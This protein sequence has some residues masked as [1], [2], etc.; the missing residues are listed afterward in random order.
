MAPPPRPRRVAPCVERLERRDAPAAAPWLAEGFDTVPAGALPPGWAQWASAGPPAFQVS[1][2]RAWSLPQGLASTPAGS[3]VAARAWYATSEPADVLVGASVFLDTA[4]PAGVLLRG[5][6]LNGT[7]A[8]YYAL[9]IS[10]GLDVQLLRVV[11]GVA[12]T[13]ADLHSTQYF[14]QQW[15]RVALWAS[16]NTLRAQVTRLD[17]GEYLTAG[18]AWRA[19]PVWALAAIDTALPGGGLAGI[20]REARYAGTVTLDDFTAAPLRPDKQ[21]PRVTL[22]A[23]AAGALLSGVVPVRAT[24]VDDVGLSRVAFYVDGTL[25]AVQ[26][27]APYGWSFD[28]TTAANGPHRLSVIATDLIGNST[29]DSVVVTT[30][31]DFA[32]AVPD[33]PRHYR[34]IRLAE[35]AYTTTPFTAQTD[36][37]LRNSIDLVVPA[38][39]YLDHVYDVAPTTPQLL[40]VNLSNLYGDA[41]TSWL[42]YADAHGLSREQAFY[43][44]ARPTPYSGGSAS[45][46]P[47]N[48]FWA[49]YRDRTSSLT[50]LT[51]QARGTSPGGVAFAGTGGSVYVGYPERFREINF[52]LASGAAGGWSGVVEYATAV[53][54]SGRPTAWARLPL[55]GDSTA[56]LTHSGQMTFDPPADWKPAV[57]NGSARLYYV[58][59]RTVTGGTAPVASSIL[60]RDYV[61]AHGG[62]AGVVPVFDYAAD[63]NHDGYLNDREYAVAVAQGDYARFAHESRLPD[64]YYGEMSFATNPSDPGFRAWA[65]QY[66]QGLLQAN[67]LAAGLFLDNSNAVLPFTLAGAPEGT[68][69]YAADYASLVAAVNRAIAPHWL[70]ANTAGGG[71]RSDAEVAGVPGYFEEFA[72]RPLA[73]NWQAFEQVAAVVGA[74]AALRTPAPYAVLDSLPTGGAPTDPRTEMAALAEYYLVADPDS[75]FLDLF[76]GYSPHSD[77]SQ[78][79]VPAVAFDVGRPLGG[80]SVFAS[81]ADP[82]NRALTY[83]V[84]Q[85][86]YGNALVLYKPLSYSHGVTGGLGDATAT[87]HALPGTFRVLNAD[88]SLG[89]AVTSITLRNGEGAVLVRTGA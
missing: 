44:A 10:R 8:S 54:A 60:G 16:G 80:W 18:G 13:L 71:G 81:G 45:S 14:S 63:T 38:P 22:T 79:W 46:L 32:V 69:T 41:L 3:R 30:Q 84:Y 43:H 34:H 19:G 21:P 40:Y 20:D 88:G 75:T 67:P 73:Q 17:T 57:L 62:T 74:R 27:A 50:D 86:S 23:P 2:A 83:D 29:T 36:A 12:T 65:V 68:G 26:T 35:L 37:L 87:T 70:L 5:A 56:G 52:S 49:V 1:A 59:V 15:V 28:T 48:W 77:W 58:R 61:G 4:A 64:G 53:D 47:V 78:H 39:A 66:A 11:N 42:A 31:N 24:A 9:T 85:R 33:I 7:R 72:L 82:A 25:R 51:G 76:G 6:R 89:P 55:L